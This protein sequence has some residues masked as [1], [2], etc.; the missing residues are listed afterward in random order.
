MAESKYVDLIRS[1]ADQRSDEWRLSRMGRMTSSEISVLFPRRSPDK[2]FAIQHEGFGQG[3]V[4]YIKRKALELYTGQDIQ[5]DLDTYA[6]RW[7][8]LLE[9]AALRFFMMSTGDATITTTGFIPHG[10]Y[11][12]GSPD[13]LSRN[14]GI[15]E[16]KCPLNQEYHVTAIIDLKTLDDLKEWEYKYW[17]QVQS[18]MY[19]TAIHAAIFMTFDPRQLVGAWTD[20]DPEGFS[21]EYAHENCSDHQK[22]MAIHSVTGEMNESVPDLIE[23]AIVRFARLRNRFIDQL[24]TSKGMPE[25]LQNW[26]P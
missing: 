3:A 13:F 21:P 11:A 6:V 5:S 4:T 22:S 18:L 16:I 1:A 8:R 12:G 20:N 23:D 9:P 19:F 24:V 17:W 10:K 7:G 26:K 14:Y 25:H 2:S 15:G